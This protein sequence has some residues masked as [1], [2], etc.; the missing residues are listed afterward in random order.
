[1]TIS[2]NINRASVILGLSILPLCGMGASLRNGTSIGEDAGATPGL[3]RVHY[4][5][6]HM[7]VQV[8]L[9]VY[10][11][12]RVT[13]DAACRVAFAR[14]AALEDVMSDYRPDSELCRLC[15][16]AGG[17]PVAVSDDLFTVLSR[18]H[19]LAER[20]GGAFDATVGP[21]VQ[22]WRQARKTG[23]WPT[24][25]EWRAAGRL[26][27]FRKMHLDSQTRTVQLDK[28][29]MRLDLGGI[30]KGYALDQAVATL[31]AH[32]VTRALASAGGD[33]ALGDAPPGRKGWRIQVWHAT[34]G[35]RRLV[36]SNCGVSTSGDTEQFVQIGRR[37]YSHIIDPRCG[38][39]HGEPIL[40]TVV[41]PDATTS[42]SLATASVVLGEKRARELV[43][44]TPGASLYLRR[45]EEPFASG[46]LPLGRPCNARS[47]RPTAPLP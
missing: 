45:A 23:V 3:Q 1:M 34:Q 46:V 30:A 31:R 5:E 20:S 42:D 18:A 26:V 36:L 37:S 43:E 40:A 32:G 12:D 15:A 2:R 33:I 38:P 35:R 41:A 7:G 39:R 29:G 9:T 8:S 19:D 22:L 17:P 11:P 13:A 4:S 21:Y 27:G 25:E 16:Q 24:D 44:A 6:V 14:I 28:A 47:G 10:A